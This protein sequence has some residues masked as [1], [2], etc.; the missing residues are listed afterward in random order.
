MPTTRAVR[1]RWLLEEMGVDYDLVR[2][3]MAMSRSSEY[4]KLHPHGKVPILVDGKVTIFESA[5]ICAYLAD[6]YCD[7]GF[8]PNLESSARG[9]YYQWLFHSALTLEAPVEQYMFHVLPGLPEKV[10]PKS[11]QVRVSPEEAQ[12]WFDKVCEPFNEHLNENDYLVENRFTAADVVTGGVLLWALKLG[13]L[14]QESP[15]KAYLS[16]LM[17]R[18][19][20]QAADEDVYAKMD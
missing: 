10:L 9:H 17:E 14:K 1:P 19:A 4:T 12:Q 7:K 20:F 2:V 3:T 13:M 11:A 18:P 16:R 8:A 5:A 6:K 15:V